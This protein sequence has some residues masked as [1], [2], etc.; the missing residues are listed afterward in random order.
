MSLGERVVATVDGT[1]FNVRQK[2][3]LPEHAIPTAPASDRTG[4][5]QEV[6]RFAMWLA[7]KTFAYA[8]SLR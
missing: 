4:A 1:K 5:E 2:Q 6:R 7:L 3:T 8:A